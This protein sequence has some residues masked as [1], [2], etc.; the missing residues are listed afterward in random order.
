MTIVKYLPVSV[1]SSPLTLTQSLDSIYKEIRSL[2]TTNMRNMLINLANNIAITTTD[3]HTDYKSKLDL[4]HAAYHH[5]IFNNKNLLIKALCFVAN[6]V[7]K[8]KY[9]SLFKSD[10][11]SILHHTITSSKLKKDC[12]ILC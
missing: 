6:K 2:D 1:F 5:R 9:R 3:L 4:I 8:K 7:N 10:A 12:I 11:Q